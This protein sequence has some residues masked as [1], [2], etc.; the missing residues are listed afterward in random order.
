MMGLAL[1]VA[2]LKGYLDSAKSLGSCQYCQGE[3]D[4]HV[5]LGRFTNV[6]TDCAC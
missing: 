3:H 6:Q 1:G 4:V 2:T 5:A